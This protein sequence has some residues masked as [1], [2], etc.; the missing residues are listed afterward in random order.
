MGVTCCD[1]DYSHGPA[2]FQKKHEL[3]TSDMQCLLTLSI[4]LSASLR[5]HFN[6]DHFPDFMSVRD[7]QEV[8]VPMEFPFDRTIS[9]WQCICSFLV[10]ECDALSER[11]GNCLRR[12]TM[13]SRMGT[14]L[15]A[16]L[17]RIAQWL[18]NHMT[19]Y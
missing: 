2:K 11:A 8:I 17:L 15:T 19:H 4:N 3:K 10:D 7:S 16:F 18:S 14:T 9:D 13:H 1:V 6:S 12:R 5:R